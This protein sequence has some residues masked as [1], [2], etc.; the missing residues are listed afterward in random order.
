[1]LW[2]CICF[3]VTAKLSK[4]NLHLLSHTSCTFQLLFPFWKQFRVSTFCLLIESKLILAWEAKPAH[5]ERPAPAAGAPRYTSVLQVTG[6]TSRTQFLCTFHARVSKKLEQV[7]WT[8][9]APVSPVSALWQHLCPLLTC[10][11]WQAPSASYPSPSSTFTFPIQKLTGGDFV[12]QAQGYTH[13]LAESS[14]SNHQIWHFLW[15]MK[16]H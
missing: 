9:S 15:E 7:L 5:S 2:Y 14:E 4:E 6:Q 16:L 11:L 12:S 8:L 1:M 10:R 13:W 3:G